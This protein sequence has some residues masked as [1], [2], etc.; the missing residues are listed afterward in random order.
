M[1]DESARS[2]DSTKGDRPIDFPS[3]PHRRLMLRHLMYTVFVA[4]LIFWVISLADF[5]LVILTFLGLG[6]L[7]VGSLITA[8]KSR[9]RNRDTLTRMLAIA[10]QHEVVLTTALTALAEDCR[11]SYRR[12]VLT[13]AAYLDYGEEFPR[14]IDQIPGVLP[15]DVEILARV[16]WFSGKFSEA[17]LEGAA[18]RLALRP[19]YNLIASRISYLTALFFLIQIIAGFL[20]YFVE[21]RMVSI[22]RDFGIALPTM[23]GTVFALG[24]LSTAWQF[25][26]TLAFVDSLILIY[27]PLAIFGWSQFG[28]P[29]LDRWFVRRHSALILRS[30]AW[31]VDGGKPLERGVNVLARSYP[32]RWVRRRLA[33][34]ALDLA[35]GIDWT[36]SLRDHSLINASDAAL[37]D[38]ARRVGNL[39][40]AMRQAAEA[41]ERRLAHRAHLLVQGIYPILLIAIGSLVMALSVAFFLPLVTLI[42]RLAG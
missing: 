26:V 14:A 11:G 36:R 17:L 31:T 23:T 16:G 15:A 24:H 7:I 20:F 22:L 29:I 10:S 2:N 3:P 32:S 13:L 41:G 33:R 37:L 4:A 12:K 27:V 19:I 35:H 5:Y 40:W 8:S 18:T 1:I 21:P 34:I 38:S 28:I 42:E 6:F 25:L 30:L 39:S 9:S